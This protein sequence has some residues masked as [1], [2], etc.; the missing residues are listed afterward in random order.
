MGVA[1]H[2]LAMDCKSYQAMQGKGAVDYDRVLT[3][4]KDHLE[5][6]IQQALAL[7][8]TPERPLVLV[9]G[10]ALHNDLHPAHA[11][12]AYSFGPAI[13]SRTRGDY[14]EVDLYVPEFVDR[15]PALR[16]EAS[17]RTWRAFARS[18]HPSEPVV[19]PRSSRSLIVVYPRGR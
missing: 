4:T 3:L 2:V 7:P 15:M 19:L 12:A 1:P 5:K 14:R 17:Y 18:A 10:G 6:A 16:K 11:L 8:R 13:F 9:Y